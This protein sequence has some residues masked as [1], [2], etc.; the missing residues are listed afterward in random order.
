MRDNHSFYHTLQAYFTLR[1]NIS[2]AVGVFRWKKHR[3]SRCFFLEDP[4]GLDDMDILGDILAHARAIYLLRKFDI[5]SLRSIA[6]WYKFLFSS[7]RDILHSSGY[8]VPK[9]Y[10]KFRQEFISLK[11]AY[12]IFS[13]LFSWQVRTIMMQSDLAKFCSKLQS[14]IIASQ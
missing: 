8:I 1:S 5:I 2:H 12:R 3:Q 9:V 10:R 11:K 7:R 4:N 13:T 6:I 14:E